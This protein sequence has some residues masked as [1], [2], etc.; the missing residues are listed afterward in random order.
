MPLPLRFAFYLEDYG[1]RFS[2]A[3]LQRGDLAVGGG[4]ARFRMLFWLAARGHGVFLLNHYDGSSVDGVQGLKV[5]V[6][7]EIPEVLGGL[8]RVHLFV[9]NYCERARQLIALD[10]PAARAKLMWAGNPFAAGWLLS[11]DGVHLHRIACVSHYHREFFRPYPNFDR[12]EIVRCGIDLDLLEKVP[13]IERSGDLVV[14]VGAPRF[15]K[16]FHNVLD[17]WP[18]VRKVHQG[19]R[20]RVVG[21]A[22]LHDPNAVGGW[23][24]VLDAD[25]EVRHLDPVV[26]PC[27]DL[28]AVGIELA[29]LV[30]VREVF[31][32]L[33]Q[34]SVVVVNCNWTGSFET[35]CRSAVE[36]Q[37]A[38]APVVGAAR[39]ALQEFVRHGETGW[40]VDEPSPR[41]LADAIVR[42]L[43]NERLRA[44]FGKAGRKWGH[45]VG[46]YDRGVDDWERIAERAI[47][48]EPAPAPKRLGGDLLRS[49]GY[50]RARIA[51][52]RLV[53]GSKV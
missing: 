24:R 26:G 53:R 13:E 19:A 46:G 23:T 21:S 4:S 27:R 18:L 48:D 52:R 40:L 8:G 11:I 50:G 22:E 29:G 38:G 16:G 25:L 32:E 30:P 7:E 44:D 51:A 34:A 17:A 43:S 1:K 14:F 2:L 49:V 6:P 45:T 12:L 42:L 28:A 37:A 33:R 35:H 47:S 36:A 9:F 39:G 31:G 5:N 10:I 15:S 41:A 3:E 20:L